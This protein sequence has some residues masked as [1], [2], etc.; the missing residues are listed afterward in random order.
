MQK[1]KSFK[2]IWIFA[3]YVLLLYASKP[4][5]TVMKNKFILY[6]ALFF[7]FTSTAYTQVDSLKNNNIKLSRYYSEIHFCYGTAGTGAALS[8]DFVLANNWGVVLSYYYLTE[9]TKKLPKDYYD[10][11]FSLLIPIKDDISFSNICFLKEFQNES[12]KLIFGIEV[13]PSIVYSH[14]AEFTPI[15]NPN[16]FLTNYNIIYHNDQAI[17]LSLRLKIET[18]FSN[19]VGLNFALFNNI[20]RIESINGCELCLTLGKVK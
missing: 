5:K 12:K 7:I 10:N 8:G 6:I 2:I 14:F 9:H 20:N 1:N 11:T 17:G 19:Y 3:F 4:K 13:G 15:P 16:I 18:S